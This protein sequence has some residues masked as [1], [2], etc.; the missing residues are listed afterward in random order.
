M[1]LTASA[2]PMYFGTMLAEGLYLRS[3]SDDD[4]VRA[5]AAY[6]PKD[7]A[8]NL[9]M[10]VGSLLVGALTPALAAAASP[11]KP[12]GKALLGAAALT[13]AAY[14]GSRRAR[15]FIKAKSKALKQKVATEEGAAVATA[16]FTG[17]AFAALNYAHITSAKTLF[18]RRLVKDLGNGPLAWLLA[19]LGW[20][21]VYYWNHRVMHESRI[22]WAMHVQ[23]H[24][25]ER[26]NLSTALR[27]PVTGPFTIAFPYAMGLL[28]VRPELVAHARAINLIY[29]YWIHT[30]VIKSI[31]PAESVLNTA[32]HHRVHHGANP[33][34][35]DKNYGSIL[36]TWDKLFGSFEPEVEPVRYGLTKNIKSFNPLTITAHEYRDIFKDVAAAP[37]LRD[38]L[39]YMFSGP[40]WAY[41]RREALHAGSV[42]P[43]DSGGEADEAAA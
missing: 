33:Q 19:V 41:E 28:G 31:G 40:G 25:S 34:Y 23:H 21:F 27:Q 24:S 7:T 20:D 32:S 30:E 36:I 38:K 8:A 17:Y 9:S 12:L 2:T 13:G 15:R 37:S 39:R 42:E 35:I 16:L 26:Y 11:R 43:P 3:R 10:G 4:R 5:L 29:Q 6:E 18:N 14:V 22:L 1:D